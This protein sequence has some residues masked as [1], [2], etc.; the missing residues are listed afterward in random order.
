[1]Y[2]RLRTKAMTVLHLLKRPLL[3]RITSL[4][5]ITRVFSTEKLTATP[6]PKRGHSIPGMVKQEDRT[7][8]RKVC[9]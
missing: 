6:P 8:K 2:A 3:I 4:V 9:Q 1:M 7:W 5:E